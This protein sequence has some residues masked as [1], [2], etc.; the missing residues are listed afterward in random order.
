MAQCLQQGAA[1]SV[2]SGLGATGLFFAGSL[3]LKPKVSSLGILDWRGEIISTFPHSFRIWASSQLPVLV[4][5]H[6]ISLAVDILGWTLSESVAG[7]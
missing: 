5:F 2:F 6:F 3:L 7:V 4:T 1:K